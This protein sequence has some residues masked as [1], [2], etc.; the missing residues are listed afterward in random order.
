MGIYSKLGMRDIR[1]RPGRSLLTLLSVVIAVA[2]MV[3]VNFA[4]QSTRRAFEEVY[5][6]VAG[7]AALE[8]SAPI[9][10]TFDEAILDTVS[11]VP[12]VKAT[13]PLM[14]RITLLYVG[15]RGIRVTAMGIDPKLDP[16]VHDYELNAGKSLVDVDGVMLNTELAKNLGVKVNDRVDLLTRIGIVKTNVVG[17]YKLH[18]AATSGHGTVMLMRLR[19]AQA[20][21]RSPRRLDT[22]QIVLD[23]DANEKTVKAAIDELLPEGV[24]AHPPA[25]RSPMAEETSLSTEQGMSMAR[26]FS[27]LVAIFIIANTFLMSVTQ[28]RRQLGIMR[29]IGATRRQIATLVFRKALLLG[30]A[31]TILG[32]I[33]GVIAATY[34][35]DAMGELYQTELPPIE[36]TWAPFL[37]AAA[38][39]IGIS[40]LGAWL[41]ASKAAHLSPM[42]AIRD[43]L[44]AAIEGVSRWFVRIG[45][46]IIL[47]CC[48]VMAACFAGK[49]DLEFAVWASVGLLI[50]LVLLLPLALRPLSRLSALVLH[51]FMP[52]E[53]RLASRQLLRHQSRTTLTVGV[54]FI[55]IATGIGLANSLIDNVNDVRE[56]YRKT[57]IADF[58]VRAMA[59]DMQTGLAADLPDDMDAEVRAVE[60]IKS[61]DAVRFVGTK[62]GEE[63]VVMIVRKFDDPEL[64]EFDLVEGDPNTVRNS[65]AKGEVVLGSVLAERAKLKAGDNIKLQTEQG[66]KEFHIAG[67]TNDY[68]AG[69]LTLY[70]ER[71]VA[72]QLLN[73]GGVDAYVIKAEPG[74]LQEV[75]SSLKKI[76]DKHGVL[77]QSFAD[78][79]QKVETMMSGVVAGLWGMVVLGLVVAAFGVTNTLMMAVVEQTREF[80]LLRVIA[81]TRQ[82]IR[83]TIVAQA[84]VMGILALV[85]G[86]AA[87]VLVAYLIHLATM[88][89]IG[90]PVKFV[91]H[92][93]L[94]TGGLVFGL[95]VVLLAAW[96]P[97][98]RAS[99]L[100]LEEALRM[101]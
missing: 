2:G 54:I 31:G 29:A 3:A 20:L 28:Q 8:I 36:L 24:A 7:R 90:H 68:Q 69:G 75:G 50:G 26:W 19:A 30:V 37:W 53:S 46:T 25:A 84:L 89:M 81:M 4:T 98:E 9:G 23:D 59:P 62:V 27:M 13:A 95:I 34:I 87:G 78:I 52:V 42:E 100:E 40:L 94:L 99:R 97:A 35:G 61:I 91:P 5:Q 64:Q 96:L 32:S 51:P 14:Q 88:S 10:D 55:A 74:R 71:D 77:L 79:Q 92:P 73:V 6:T 43:V 93:W 70:V 22:I 76:T 56:W 18:G 49:L 45:I 39:G 65:L 41:P 11:K 58:F 72:R 82:Q 57:I 101:E 66:E 38:F 63:Q 80:A 15:K 16:A 67:V 1:Q 48:A 17:L 33:L 83:K 21:F 86:V 12:G 85:P 60:G 44:P 47:I